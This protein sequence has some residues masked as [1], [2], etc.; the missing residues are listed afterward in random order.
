[1]E[2]RPVEDISVIETEYMSRMKPLLADIF[3]IDKPFVPATDSKKCD[4]CEYK[5][6]CGK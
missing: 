3:D 2:K 6:I 4:Y 1:M 5:E